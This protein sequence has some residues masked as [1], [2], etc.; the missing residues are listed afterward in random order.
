MF[1]PSDWNHQ[2]IHRLDD[3]IAAQDPPSRRFFG[4]T[5]G[6]PPSDSMEGRSP[7][8]GISGPNMLAS[9]IKNWKTC[10]PNTYIWDLYMGPIR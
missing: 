6:D 8:P 10:I 2:H 9:T 1:Q 7:Q 4:E 3:P 5:K